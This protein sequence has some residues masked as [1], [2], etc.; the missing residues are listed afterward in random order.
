[1]SGMVQ[2]LQRTATSL[3]PAR[4][5]ALAFQ[6]GSEI[7]SVHWQHSGFAG[8]FWA[9]VAAVFPAHQCKRAETHHQMHTT[10]PVPM[11]ERE[12]AQTAA[13]QPG[14]TT[15]WRRTSSTSPQVH[16]QS[17][18]QSWKHHSRAKFPLLLQLQDIPF[19]EDKEH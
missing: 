1:M 2:C 14:R 3:L 17:K 11:Q 5:P 12:Q 6:M 10:A 15:A 16:T 13:A 19:T 9:E 8:V 4:N 7:S 18:R